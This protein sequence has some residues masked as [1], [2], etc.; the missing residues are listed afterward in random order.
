VKAD[1]P[2]Y[3]TLMT[4]VNIHAK[5]GAGGRRLARTQTRNPKPKPLT[6]AHTQTH[7]PHRLDKGLM[8]C[9]TRRLL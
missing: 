5:V 9:K 4:R 3:L 8:C 2:R 6:M 7:D 1:E